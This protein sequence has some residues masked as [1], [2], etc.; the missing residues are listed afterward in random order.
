MELLRK[1]SALR[2]QWEAEKRQEILRALD[3]DDA[4]AEHLV[5]T[6]HGDFADLFVKCPHC[7]QEISLCSLS[8]L[9]E[10]ERWKEI[11]ASYIP[12]FERRFADHLDYCQRRQAARAS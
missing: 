5:I 7:G 4:D 12:S 3:L 6:Y 2:A 9:E 10:A 1:L 11:I 8:L